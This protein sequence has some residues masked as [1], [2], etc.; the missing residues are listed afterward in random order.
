MEKASKVFALKEKPKELIFVTGQPKDINF[1]DIP[2][3]VTWIQ[4]LI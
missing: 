3:R 2:K 4:D 1:R